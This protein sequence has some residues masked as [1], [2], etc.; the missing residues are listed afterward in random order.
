M[1]RNERWDGRAPRSSGAWQNAISTAFLVGVLI[2]PLLVFSSAR[3]ALSEGDLNLVD[4]HTIRGQSS[5][6]LA[7]M[8]SLSGDGSTVIVGQPGHW[9]GWATRHRSNIQVKMWNGSSWVSKGSLP[10]DANRNIG[11]WHDISDNGDVVS[12]SSSV[13]DEVFVA[14]WNGSSWV[15]RPSIE[16]SQAS[17]SITRHA[18][19][20]DGE[21]LVVGERGFDDS[22][23]ANNGKVRTLDWDG[24]AWVERPAFIGAD[25]EML[26]SSA[27]GSIA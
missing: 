3:Q 6:R 14:D 4:A 21:V 24:S 8:P 22:A 26:G 10:D 2:S 23:D 16:G 25:G 27:K 17:V 11:Y 12:Y 7:F 13:L 20:G 15:Q 18:L 5:Y 1:D 19:S 9:A